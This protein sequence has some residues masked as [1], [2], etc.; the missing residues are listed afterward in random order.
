MF[1]VVS[2]GVTPLLLNDTI[3]GDW[4]HRPARGTARYA[5]I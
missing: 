3:K 4:V 1:I 5:G 2:L